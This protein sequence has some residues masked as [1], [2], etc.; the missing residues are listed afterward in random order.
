MLG[1]GPDARLRLPLGQGLIETTEDSVSLNRLHLV[2]EADVLG[3]SGFVIVTGPGSVLR[4]APE[5]S[6][7][8]S[9]T[10]ASSACSGGRPDDESRAFFAGLSPMPEEGLEPPTRGL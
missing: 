5:W 9:L 4:Y 1:C 10:V 7:R 2:G 3:L 6:G 8:A